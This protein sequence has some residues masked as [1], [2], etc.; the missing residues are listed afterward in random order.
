[1]PLLYGSTIPYTWFD[2]QDTN[3]RGALI[4]LNNG[5]NSGLK[6]QLTPSGRAC[7][8]GVPRSITDADSLPTLPSR[9]NIMSACEKAK[10][11]AL[12]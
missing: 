11:V 6:S 3:A 5:V 9:S 8:S 4:W 1:V 10:A 7:T 12:I 2:Y